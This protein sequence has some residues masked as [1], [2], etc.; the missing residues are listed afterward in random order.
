MSLVEDPGLIFPPGY[1]NSTTTTFYLNPQVSG[2]P[3]ITNEVYV[4]TQGT[5]AAGNNGTVTNPF[6]TLFAALQY[7]GVVQAGGSPV[8]TNVYVGPGTYAEA[9][10]PITDNVNVIGGVSS[11]SDAS[12]SAVDV[13]PTVIEGTIDFTASGSST[14]SMSLSNITLVGQVTVEPVFF[15]T[16]VTF[17]NCDLSPALDGPAVSVIGTAF[18]ANLVFQGCR[19]STTNAAGAPVLNVENAVGCV[20]TMDECEVSS[21][22][23]TSPAIF[24]AGSLIMNE[25]SV[26]NVASGDTLPPLISVVPTTAVDVNLSYCSASYAD[27]STTDTGGRKLVIEYDTGAAVNVTSVLT[28]NNFAV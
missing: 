23:L 3:L 13:P 15:T 18:A 17:N 25:S 28:N 16:N 20:V 5:D 24:S 7:I 27:V 9:N 11:K 2:Q 1:V 6:R 8:P 12:L 22:S 21:S 26:I 4:S 19:L 10:L 14:A